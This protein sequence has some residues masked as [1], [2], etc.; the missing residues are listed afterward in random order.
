MKVKKQKIIIIVLLTVLTLALA[1]CS[2]DDSKEVTSPTD[3]IVWE[4]FSNQY[5][6]F[7]YPAKWNKYLEDLDEDSF[8]IS[9]GPD[10]IEIIKE[11]EITES[12][13]IYLKLKSSED[14][15]SS[16]FSSEEE[17]YNY[18]KTKWED[19][20]EDSNS[21]NIIA[22]K[23]I[24]FKNYPAYKITST[25]EPNLERG[26]KFKLKL[27]RIMVYKNQFRQEISYAAK[28]DK[29]NQALADEII[30]SFKFLY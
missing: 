25:I 22:T 30:D 20:D 6:S 11:E 15:Y 10:N 1:A 18:M 29:Y 17:F 21:E 7:K 23:K 13:S 14:N 12:F 2:G 28:E 4:S 27:Q 19:S 8:S 24:V 3:T 16:K 5:V 26:L 9:Y